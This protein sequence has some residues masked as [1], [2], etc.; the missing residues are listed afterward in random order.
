MRV[1]GLLTPE[2]CQALL[3]ALAAVPMDHYD[4]A[5]VFPVVAKFGPAVNDH[6]RAGVLDPAYWEAAR[7]AEKA[8]SRLGVPASP[9]KVCL[10]AFQ[11]DWPEVRPARRGFEE[12]HVGVVREIN[13]GLQ[14]HVD[15]VS[16]E[17]RDNLVGLALTAQFAFNVYLTVPPSGGETV[18]WQRRWLPGDDATGIPGG[19]GY[20]EV[21]TAGA[22]QVVVRPAVGEGLLFDPR[23]YHTVR[24]AHGGRRVS[25]GCF[26]GLDADDQMILWS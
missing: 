17:Y 18:V 25:I 6:R 22:S 9:R 23:N 24:R 16:R 4:R 21:V 2:E 19:Y 10:A 26:V 3:M 12:L 14:V 11:D 1:P 15:D 5:R 13:G 7:A 8:W 20:D